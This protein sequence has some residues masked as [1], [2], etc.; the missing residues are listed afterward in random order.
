MKNQNILKKIR[1]MELV[2]RSGST[3]RKKEDYQKFEEMYAE[4]K[5]KAHKIDTL[6]QTQ[7]K[8]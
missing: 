2:K 6:R 3:E 1:E 8:V 5:N 7:D 4:Y